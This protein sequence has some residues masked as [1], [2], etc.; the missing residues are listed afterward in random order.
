MLAITLVVASA[1]VSC[2]GKLGSAAAIDLSKSPVQKVDSMFAVQTRNGAVTMRMEAPL[3]EKYET[4]TLSCED[5]PKGI[6]VFG[7]NEDGLLETIIVSDEARHETPK[8]R[9]EDEVWKAYGNVIIHN[10]IKKQTMETDTIFW[11]RTLNQIYTDC[12]VRMYSP[13]GF[14]QGYGMRS[15]DHARNAVLLSPFNSYGVSQQDT[16]RVEVDSINFIGPFRK[17]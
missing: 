7:Y 5:F 8:R 10:V 2:G 6:K 12:Y 3:M 13:D 15:D 11:D 1:L 17:K 14:M 9:L 4:D 16:T